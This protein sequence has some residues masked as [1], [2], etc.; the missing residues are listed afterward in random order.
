MK[1]WDGKIV[2]TVSV[3]DVDH[4]VCEHY[5]DSIKPLAKFKLYPNKDSAKMKVKISKNVTSVGGVNLT[6]F[7]VNSNIATTGHKLQG[8]TKD[9]LIVYSWNY[10]FTN[11]IYVVLSRVRTLSGLYLCKKLDETKELLCDEDLLREE[12]RLA[13]IE[14]RFLMTVKFVHWAS[15]D[16]AH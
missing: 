15:S 4:M 10:T 1:Q 12:E 11:W 14:L 2:P 13:D 16:T 9:A 6:Q 7:P 3:D 5:A 8:M